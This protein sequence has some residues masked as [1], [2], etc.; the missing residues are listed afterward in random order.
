MKESK[1]YKFLRPL[2]KIFT[3]IVYRPTYIGLENIPKN[4]RIVIAGN[5]TNNLDC[6]LLMSST[7]RCIHFLAKIELFK[8]FKK[9]IFSNMGLIPVNRKIKDSNVIKE[10]EKYLNEDLVIGIF[11]EGTT[12][13]KKELL[14]FKIGAVKMAYDTDSEIIPFA[15]I[16]KYKLFKNNLTIIFDKPYKIQSN[17]LEY[18]NN[19]LRE[20]VKKLI[21][22]GE[23]HG[24]NK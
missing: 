19:K 17:D 5:H 14:P 12:N 2:I 24:N 18:E 9:I 8:G 20:K 3:N 21:K 15:I 13:T 16:G 1:L 10:A 11:P 6:I 7:K 22:K 23:K 4:K